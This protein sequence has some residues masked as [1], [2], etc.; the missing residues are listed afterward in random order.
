MISLT[1]DRYEELFG[2]VFFICFFLFIDIFTFFDKTLI[3]G[4]FTPVSDSS[5][6]LF[7]F[8]KFILKVSN[9]D[10]EIRMLNTRVL[11]VKGI[12]EENAALFPRF[13]RV[14]KQPL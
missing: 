7:S 2:K 3:E 4:V 12:N 14:L 9:R 1:S 6:H 13:Y 8:A 5:T 10:K 11:S